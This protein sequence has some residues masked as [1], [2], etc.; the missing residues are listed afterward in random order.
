MTRL[1]AGR[2]IALSAALATVATTSALA[3]A[4]DGVEDT[5]TR[6]TYVVG[7]EVVHPPSP[8]ARAAR[9][10][11]ASTEGS[12]AGSTRYGYVVG[13]VLVEPAR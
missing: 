11:P 7:G 5:S 12:A 3:L 2:V 1:I 4:S 13:G 8:H 6:H 9:R 10:T